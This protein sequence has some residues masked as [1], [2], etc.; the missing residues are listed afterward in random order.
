M[1]VASAQTSV[2]TKDPV[3]GITNL[4]RLDSTVACAGA[5]KP[6]AMAEVK[7]MGFVTVVNLRQ[8]SEAGADLEAGAAAATAAGLRYVHLPFNGTTPDPAVVD[9][10]VTLMSDP[11]NQPAFIHCAS[12]NRAAALWMVKRVLLDKWD[13]QRA[14]EE[15]A[16]LG[17]T[18]GTLK[19][20]VTDYVQT[21]AR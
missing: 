12:G 5:T 21:H 11:T 14:G 13:V 6:E 20:F 4:A 3:T 16:A 15:A 19:Q 10:F 18:S 7:R 2:V 8:A 9:R 1:R 17:L